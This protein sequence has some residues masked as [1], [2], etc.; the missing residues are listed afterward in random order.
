MNKINYVFS[1]K[2]VKDPIGRCIITS[3]SLVFHNYVRIT[4]LVVSLN[5]IL[6][7][8]KSAKKFFV[9]YEVQT[10][11]SRTYNLLKLD[12][13]NYSIIIYWN[14]LVDSAGIFGEVVGCFN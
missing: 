1:F 2:M 12:L 8:R 6:W 4:E 9:Y 7:L 5:L 14:F 13:T 11:S 3:L 10:G